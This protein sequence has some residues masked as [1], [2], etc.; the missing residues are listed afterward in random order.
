MWTETTREKYRRDE[1]PYAS[2][3]REAEWAQIAPLLPPPR[4]AGAAAQL[5][6]C[7]RLST[8]FSI[9]GWS[10]CQWRA[11][12]RE[13]PPRSTVQRYFY[14]WRDDGTWE[15]HQCRAGGA[16]AASCS[17]DNATPVGRHHRQPECADHRKRRP[18]RGRRGQ[19]HQGAQAPHR[20]RYARLSAR[21]AGARGQ[22]PGPTRRGAV[23]ARSAAPL[24]RVAAYLRRPRLSRPATA[25][26][27]SPIAAPGRSRSSSA[28]R[29]QRLPT[30][31]PTLG[32]RAQPSP[33]S[34]AVG[35]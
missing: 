31:A 34:A 20:H 26:A 3:T 4:R 5:A 33:G 6:I 23:A 11:L 17:G 29:R 16:R 27:R 28:R 22:H 15:R 13:F 7:A 8:L 35:P 10:G 24:S 19:A 25:R 1:L 21:R 32:G 14:R 18:A 9:S 12:P 2:D 30:A